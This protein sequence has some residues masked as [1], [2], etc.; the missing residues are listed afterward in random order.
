M[1]T[2]RPLSRPLWWGAW[3]LVCGR[4]WAATPPLSPPTGA[5]LPTLRGISCRPTRSPP[6][7]VSWLRSALSGAS[8]SGLW[9]PGIFGCF[10][11]CFCPSAPPPP[12]G[13]LPL[14]TLPIRS[15]SC[16]VRAPFGHLI[17]RPSPAAPPKCLSPLPARPGDLAHSRGYPLRYSRSR[18]AAA[19]AGALCVSGGRGGLPA[20]A[21][22]SPRGLELVEV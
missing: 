13:G 3:S 10:L 9:F 18:A 6:G 22:R 15:T 17:W 5:L 14:L 2:A 19:R 20:N 16:R 21:P 11:W 12:P 4:S 8:G 1:A 7:C